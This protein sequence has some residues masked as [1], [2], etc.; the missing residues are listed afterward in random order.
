[1]LSSGLFSKLRDPKFW[2]LSL[3]K[4]RPIISSF[5]R[6][7][8]PL[9]R[10]LTVVLEHL[11]PSSIRPGGNTRTENLLPWLRL[12]RTVPPRF[13]NDLK[14]VFQSLPRLVFQWNDPSCSNVAPVTNL[15]LGRATT[16]S[17]SSQWSKKKVAVE[18]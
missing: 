16:R 13:E 9:V 17:H 1:M 18:T 11:P 7:F 2:L 10:F 5:L 14:R 12:P 8:L 15:C 6:L 4:E 3:I